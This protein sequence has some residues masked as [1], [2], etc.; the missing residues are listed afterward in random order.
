M[1]IRGRGRGGSTVDEEDES[2]GSLGSV[3]T[4]NPKFPL[5]ED[6]IKGKKCHAELGSTMDYKPIFSII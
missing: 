3:I 5:E 6:C 2:T 4:D 1:V